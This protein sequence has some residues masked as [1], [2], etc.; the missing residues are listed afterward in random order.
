MLSVVKTV[1]KTSPVKQMETANKQKKENFGQKYYYQVR[2][3]GTHTHI[4]SP[5]HTDCFVHVDRHH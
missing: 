4:V 2:V 3:R 5:S 1:N